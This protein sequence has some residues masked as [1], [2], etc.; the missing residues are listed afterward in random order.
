M[1]GWRWKSWCAEVRS[2]DVSSMHFERSGWPPR[3]TWARRPCYGSPTG[4]RL[5]AVGD[6]PFGPR[7]DAIPVEPVMVEVTLRP[8]K[9]LGRGFVFDPPR[10]FD[11]LELDDADRVR[12]EHAVDGIPD[13][14]R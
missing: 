12:V 5:R 11:V 6:V 10:G 4:K 8:V 7:F 1:R 3:K 9:P 14:Q 2:M 13:Q